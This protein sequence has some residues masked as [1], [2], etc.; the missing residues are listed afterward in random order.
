M[1]ITMKK[2][3]PVTEKKTEIRDRIIES[4]LVHVPFDGWSKTALAA[5][6]RDAGYE[7]CMALRVFGGGMSEVAD[8]FSDWSDRRMLM[9]LE[10]LDADVM[11]VRERIH[12]GIKTRL[13]LN[14]P[15]REAIRRLASFLAL[16]G[17]APLAARLAWRTS[18]GIWYWAGDRSADWNHYS[19]RGLLAS[20][21]TS[22]ILYWLADEADD[23]GDYPETWAFL[24]RRIED[25]LRVFGLPK[26]L[27]KAFGGGPGMFRLSKG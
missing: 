25:V 19:K 3:A 12:A 10:K 9:E 14:A 2:T 24:D 20:V 16:P 1:A 15:Y 27:K 18:S 6:V 11:K 22:T 5:G 13:H 26:R 23:N 21:Y 17:N 4:F 7:P 8:H